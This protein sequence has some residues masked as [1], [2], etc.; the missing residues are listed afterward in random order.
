VGAVVS[1]LSGVLVA[2]F[3]APAGVAGAA[4]PAGIRKLTTGQYL[5]TGE[6]LTSANGRYFAA[7]DGQGRLVVRSTGGTVQWRSP[8]AGPGAYARLDTRGE[9]SLRVAGRAVWSTHTRGAGRGTTLSVSN[10]G[11]L[12]LAAKRLFVWSTELPYACPRASGKVFVVD[13]SRQWARMCA[14]GQQ[15]RATFVTT[16]ASALGNG[17]PTGT[18]HVYARTRNTTLYPAAG[19]AYPVKYWMPY[20]GAYGIHDSSWQHFA[21]GSMKYKTRGSHGC[22]HVPLRAMTWLFTWAKVGTT[23][24]IH[25]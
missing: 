1:V 22:T 6:R 8:A 24:T 4:P 20:D 2:G 18:W 16:G 13:L 14:G 17:T 3:V 19:G 25:A 15:I 21:Y 5:H 7:L 9:L 23:V 12:A 10:A 11:V